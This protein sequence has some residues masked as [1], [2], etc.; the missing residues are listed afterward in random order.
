MQ[1]LKIMNKEEKM[2]R[3]KNKQ[4]I[5]FE[6]QMLRGLRADYSPKHYFVFDGLIYARVGPKIRHK[7]EVKCLC[8][9]SL[10]K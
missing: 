8:V 1:N 2:I 3:D 5:L 6:R 7:R 4:N 9:D 10:R